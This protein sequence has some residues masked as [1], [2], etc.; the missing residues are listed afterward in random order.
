MVLEKEKLDKLID[1]YDQ[2]AEKAYRNYQETGM[3]RYQTEQHN[4]EDLADT[5]RIALSAHD[6]H[7]KLA[8]M[9]AAV[10][11]YAKA[12]DQYRHENPMTPDGFDAIKDFVKFAELY[13]KYKSPYE[14]AK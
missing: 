4:N 9:T 11:N 2:K 14:E 5:L 1:R 13:C 7:M 10:V 12:F 3:Q 8:T 6:D